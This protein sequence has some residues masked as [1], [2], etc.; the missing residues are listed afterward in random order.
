MPAAAVAAELPK[1]SDVVLVGHE[2]DLG[3]L[4]RLLCGA[5]V[6]LKKC[7]L[8]VLEGDPEEDGMALLAL[9]PPRFIMDDDG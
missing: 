9:L 6:G 8:A 3:T 1:R 7:G 2:P 5:R 4:I